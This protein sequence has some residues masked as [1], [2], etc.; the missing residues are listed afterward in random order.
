MGTLYALSLG[1][2][3]TGNG[4]GTIFMGMFDGKL[5]PSDV[6]NDAE[7]ALGDI[8]RKV[9]AG[10]RLQCAPE[11]ALAGAKHGFAATPPDDE[12]LGVR[13]QL[14]FVLAHPQLQPRA[15]GELFPMIKAAGAFWAA[16]AWE[17]LPGDVA[18]EVTVTGAVRGTF[19]AAVMGAAGEEYGL[20]LYPKRGSIAKIAAAVDAGRPDV[21]A[22]VDAVSL[23]YEDS[24]GF[25]VRAIEAWCGLPM[26]PVAFGMRGGRRRPLEPADALALAVTLHAMSLMKGEP[27]ETAAHTLSAPGVEVAVTVRVPDGKTSP[28]TP[29]PRRPS[30]RARR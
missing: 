29:K 10:T 7:A 1:P 23:T 2:I 9:P 13:A 17:R 18:I 25:A 24:P 11:L 8:R 20:A 26:V 21:A 4:Y 16:R 6:T 5:V 27:G 19:E 14:A 28:P 3:P 30:R 15:S 12:V 22:Q